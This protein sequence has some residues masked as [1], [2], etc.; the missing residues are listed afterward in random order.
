[1]PNSSTITANKENANS[2]ISGNNIT[3]R[4]QEKNKLN[5]ACRDRERPGP[6]YSVRPAAAE[7]GRKQTPMEKAV[8]KM[9]NAT[10][11]FVGLHFSELVSLADLMPVLMDLAECIA[12]MF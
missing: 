6:K 4:E 9:W 1:M 5:A 7:G 10:Q 12:A 11:C 2:T 8:R 3:S